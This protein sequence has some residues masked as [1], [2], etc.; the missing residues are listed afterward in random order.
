MSS[1]SRTITDDSAQWRDV[2]STIRAGEAPCISA[3]AMKSLWRTVSVSA[4][5]SR[6]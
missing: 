6:A 5:A 4:R 3:A 2:D 1:V